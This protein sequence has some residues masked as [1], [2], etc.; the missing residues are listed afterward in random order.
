MATTEV[1]Q[2]AGSGLNSPHLE[3]SGRG[4]FWPALLTIVGGAIVVAFFYFG[5]V[6]GWGSSSLMDGALTHEVARERLQVTVTDDGNVESARNI[7][8]KCDVAGGGTILWIVEDGKEVSQGEE[9]IRLDTAEIYDQLNA[10]RILYERA[11]AAKIQA[12]EDFEAA[13][14]TVSEYAKGLSVELLQQIESE[15]KIAE[16]NLSTA[17]DM[18]QYSKRMSR[19]GYVSALQREADVFAVERAQLDMENAQTRKMVLQEYTRPKMIREFEAIRDANEAKMRSEEAAFALEKGRLERLERQLDNCIIK[20]PQ[21]GMVVYANETGR[22]GSDAATIEEGAIVRERQTI[23]RL[24]DLNRM[25]VKV[26]VHESKVD[27]VQIGMPAKVVIQ[28]RE[29]QGKVSSI[30]N[31]PEP[32]GWFSASVKEYATM[33]NIEGEQEGLRPGLTAFVEIMVADVSNVL[34]VPVSSVV[35]QGRNYYAWVAT[36]NGPER[37]VLSLGRTND[38]MIEVVDGVVEGERVLRNPRAIVTAAR[39]ESEDGEGESPLEDYDES[40]EKEEGSPAVPGQP[41][42]QANKQGPPAS[43]GPGGNPIPNLD[44]DGDGKISREEAPKPMQARFDQI[45]SDGDGQLSREELSAARAARETA[46]AA[47]PVSSEGAR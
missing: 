36:A 26:L 33:V 1:S 2:D 19:K 7:D 41:V 37:R 4:W 38:K 17:Q 28:G 31:Q 46:G 20:A 34:T 47:S 40:T 27:R 8:I 45:D 25:Q 12:E 29:F 16:Q 14:L 30:A 18:L 9:I 43:G 44:Q 42:D 10:Q 13:K 11:L 3:S 32:T 39:I 15:I 35:E 21:S 5:D 22:R 6:T 24:P 23:V